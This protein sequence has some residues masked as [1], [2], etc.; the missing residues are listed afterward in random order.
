MIQSY[1]ETPVLLA[2]N[3]SPLTFSTDCIRTRCANCYG[4]LQH[5]QGSPL[6][7][8][9]NGGTYDVTFN[10]N[11]TSAT[12]GQVALGLYMDGVLLPGTTVIADIT[13]AGNYVNVAFT[14][15]VPICCRG[16]ATLTVQSVPSILTGTTT[17]G[18]P[19]DT[20]IPLYQNANFRIN[21]R[22]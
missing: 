8:I 14:K 17:T 7:K 5:S 2:S 9:L 22:P 19:T 18:T 16:N 21:K 20:Q 11:V 4:F 3:S 6:Y 10:A 1:Q 12:A 13:T 15:T